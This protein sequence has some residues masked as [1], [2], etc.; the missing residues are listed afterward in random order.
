MPKCECGFSC[1]PIVFAD[2]H[3]EM[4]LYTEADSNLRNLYLALYQD[5]FLNNVC[6]DISKVMI[7]AYLGTRGLDILKWHVVGILVPDNSVMGSIA[8][9]DAVNE[10][11]F[12]F[13][14]PRMLGFELAPLRNPPLVNLSQTRSWTSCHFM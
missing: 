5:K 8:C 9:L 2:A 7:D 3:V 10:F 13:F 14:F 1:A 4:T 11:L 12:F 6:E